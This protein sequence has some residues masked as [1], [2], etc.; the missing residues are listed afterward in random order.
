MSQ[1]RDAYQI[2]GLSPTA[3]AREVQIAY[4]S[5]AKRTHPD[6][7]G[8]P[9]EFKTVRAAYERIRT[10]ESRRNY[11]EARRAW[12][13][14]GAAPTSE[15]TARAT[16]RP[17]TP[18]APPDVGASAPTTD[19][20]PPTSSGEYRNGASI[21]FVGLVSLIIFGWTTAL[22]SML[23][24]H[25]LGFGVA[26]GLVTVGLELWL[27]G[28]GRE[29][30]L[31][32]LTAKRWAVVSIAGWFVASLVRQAWPALVTVGVLIVLGSADTLRRRRGLARRDHVD[33]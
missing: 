32:W 10:D 18:T 27:W 4:R 22:S 21:E 14:G 5:A 28:W 26:V 3:S 6:R 25:R 31:G 19:P 30:R 8:D 11:D 15:P 9:E 7:G 16:P 2:L 33:D 12:T 13:T 1:A 24:G 17:Q 20:T 29:R 23:F